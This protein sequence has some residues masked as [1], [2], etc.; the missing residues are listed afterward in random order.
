MLWLFNRDVKCRVCRDTGWVTVEVWIGSRGLRTTERC[1]EC[2][3]V[4]KEKS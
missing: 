2:G 1:T 3:P 4:K